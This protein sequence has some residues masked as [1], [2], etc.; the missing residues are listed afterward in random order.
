M[1]LNLKWSISPRLHRTW[2]PNTPIGLD[3]LVQ[4]TG[5]GLAEDLKVELTLPTAV[6]CYS[7]NTSIEI[8]ALAPGETIPITYDM[9]VPSKF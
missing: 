5:L 6:N 3:L 1:L 8:P 4:N 9:M 2:K 7:N